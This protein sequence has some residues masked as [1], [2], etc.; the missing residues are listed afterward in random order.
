MEGDIPDVTIRQILEELD[1]EGIP[2]VVANRLAEAT[3]GAL[4]EAAQGWWD[5][6]YS[7]AE[8]LQ[9]VFTVSM[10][11]VEFLA[12]NREDLS[13]ARMEAFFEAKKRALRDKMTSMS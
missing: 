2:P 5:L 6:R 12:S 13:E 3:I 8:L 10:M 4:K 1:W 11:P 7:D 9:K